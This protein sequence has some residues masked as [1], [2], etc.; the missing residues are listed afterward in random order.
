MGSQRFR[1]VTV[2]LKV[3]KMLT[4]KGPP[5]PLEKKLKNFCDPQE[6]RGSQFQARNCSFT[7][8]ENFD[9]QGS[10]LAT[11]EKVEH[12]LKSQRP[13]ISAIP[14]FFGA[15]DLTATKLFQNSD[16]HFTSHFVFN[17][18]NY[19]KNTRIRKIQCLNFPPKILGGQRT[20]QLADIP[21]T[22]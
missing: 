1:P 14:G 17:K 2:R 11:Q 3:S 18:Q 15:L 22:L 12:F 8:F 21:T 4:T 19:F 5:M 13:E 9:Y 16:I 7:S 10:P 20:T 6:P